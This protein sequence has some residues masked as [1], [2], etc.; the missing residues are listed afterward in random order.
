MIVPNDKL[1]AY[2]LHRVGEQQ[3]ESS[4]IPY[5]EK[6]LELNT[7]GPSFIETFGNCNINAYVGFIDLA[8]F[9]TKVHGKKAREIASYLFPFLKKI[10]EILGERFVLIDKMIGDEIMFILLD[11]DEIGMPPSI[12]LLGKILDCFYDIAFDM[13]PKYKYRIGLSY[14]EVLVAHLQAENYSEWTIVGEPV[15]VA[16]RLESVKELKNPNPILG[17]FGLQLNQKPTEEIYIKIKNILDLIAGFASHF[18][19]KL[20]NKPEEFK[21]V[22]K[23]LWAL[24]FPKTNNN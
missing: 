5:G 19:H 18:D 24:F 10:I 9:S 16:K 7:Y 20:N 8:E 17:A 14:G 4:P 6:A 12:L 2:L 3:L 21:G 23:V 22:G 11:F 13:A 15:H 1:L